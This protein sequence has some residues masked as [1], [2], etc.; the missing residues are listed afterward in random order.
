MKRNQTWQIGLHRLG[1][2]LDGGAGLWDARRRTGRKRAA[3]FVLSG[4]QSLLRDK[5]PVLAD[6]LRIRVNACGYSAI[7][8]KDAVLTMPRVEVPVDGSVMLQCARSSRADYA[9][10]VS[11]DDLSCQVD[12]S[13]P[14]NLAA[15]RVNTTLCVAYQ[16]I[17]TVSG[18]VLGAKTLALCRITS[19]IV[20]GTNVGGEILD[21][22]LGEVADRI[23]EHLASMQSITCAAAPGS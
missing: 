5:I 3:L 1:A 22:L 14:C 23:S 15:L 11:L 4:A 8:P 21:R 19:P 18:R 13:R 10:V 12:E 20:S 6:L 9:L 17:E 7:R 16:F 2:R